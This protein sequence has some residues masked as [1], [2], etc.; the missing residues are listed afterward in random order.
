MGINHTVGAPEGNQR[1]RK[2]GPKRVVLPCRIREDHLE[3]LEAQA[4][5]RQVKLAVIIDEV[6]SQVTGK[7]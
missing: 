5:A 7:N 3:A 1:A 6:L 4:E 2:S